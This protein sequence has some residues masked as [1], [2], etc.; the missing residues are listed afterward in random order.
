MSF[1]AYREFVQLFQSMTGQ[2][3]TTKKTLDIN[4]KGLEPSPSLAA[5]EGTQ[6]PDDDKPISASDAES[7][8]KLLS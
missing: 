8:L 6:M 7:M 1:K 5:G 3:N 4:V 2:D